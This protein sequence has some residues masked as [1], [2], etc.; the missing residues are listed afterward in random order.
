MDQFMNIRGYIVKQGNLWVAV[1]IDY[2]LACQDYDKISCINK[3]R[4]QISDYLNDT[5]KKRLSPFKFICKYYIIKLFKPNNCQLLQLSYPFSTKTCINCG[6]LRLV[7]LR[8]QNI[9]V[10]G[11]CNCTM[12]WHL[13]QGQKP[14]L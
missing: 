1:C 10:C 2:C 6:S 12:K 3:I 5:T 7:L 9:K 13:Q 14:L 11:D 4:D 8:S